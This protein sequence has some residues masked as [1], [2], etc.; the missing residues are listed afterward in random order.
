[1]EEFDASKHFAKLVASGQFKVEEDG[2]VLL[3]GVPALFFPAFVF[4]KFC[5]DVPPEILYNIGAYQAKKAVE[6]HSKFFGLVFSAAVTKVLTGIM[7]KVFEFIL[8]TMS[9][10]GFG[11]FEIQKFDLQNKEMVI[12]NKTNPVA[13]SYI[14][15][16]G[17]AEK[18][19]DHY[20]V[21]LLEGAA[22]YLG[23]EL[24][25]REEKCIACGDP[26]C[27]FII[28]LEEKNENK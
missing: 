13:R 6:L 8:R 28:K 19:I 15:D 25:C 20:I 10:L 3:E 21:G 11:V 26:E 17:K 16:F 1:M 24:K 23:G 12:I 7:D 22:V 2:R 18:P 4:A 5:K 9:V 14:R 27:V